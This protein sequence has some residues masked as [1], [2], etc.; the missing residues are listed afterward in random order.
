[1]EFQNEVSWGHVVNSL[2]NL[3]VT[4]HPYFRP[5][6]FMRHL[7]WR[8]WRQHRRMWDRGDQVH[9]W[10]HLLWGLRRFRILLQISKKVGGWHGNQIQV[11][12]SLSRPVLLAVTYF[13]SFRCLSQEELHPPDRPM[14]CHIT[15]YVRSEY[16]VGC[17]DNVAFCNQNLTII[18]D[19]GRKSGESI[20]FLLAFACFCFCLAFLCLFLML[21]YSSSML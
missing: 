4:Y 1:M 14:S 17:C 8:P 21:G 9:Q 16:N 3:H 6:M 19:E 2:I 7:Q 11:R 10:W 12:W 18:L 20:C 15:D 13:G 5:E